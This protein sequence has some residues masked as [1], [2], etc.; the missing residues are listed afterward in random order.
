MGVLHP[1][2]QYSYIRVSFVVVC[3]LFL[4]FVCFFVC[5]INV[6]EHTLLMEKVMLTENSINNKLK[7]N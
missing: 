3:L 5:F 1:V 2:N 7:K 4:L 6:R